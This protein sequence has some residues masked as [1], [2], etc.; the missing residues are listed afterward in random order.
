MS[1]PF[2]VNANVNKLQLNLITM[3]KKNYFVLLCHYL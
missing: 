3:N 1:V 2:L